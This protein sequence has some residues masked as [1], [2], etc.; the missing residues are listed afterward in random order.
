MLEG[1]G[2]FSNEPERGNSM[3]KKGAKHFFIWAFYLVVFML[4]A[5]IIFGRKDESA[6]KNDPNKETQAEFIK[7]EILRKWVPGK[8]G[9]AMEILVSPANTK[10]EVIALAKHLKEENLKYGQVILFIYDLREAC[11]NRDNDKYPEEKYFKHFLLSMWVP[12][13]NR[14]DPEIKWEAKGRE[15]PKKKAGG[16]ALTPKKSADKPKSS[17]QI[18]QEEKMMKDML[19][20]GLVEKINPELNEA[21][22]DPSVWARMKYQDKEYL[23]RFLAFYCGKKKGTNLNWVDIRD[24]YT[25]KKFAKY[26]EAWGFKVY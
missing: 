15:E 10:E 6:N 26:S 23:G 9:I 24:S 16:P 1:H 22:V 20:A 2:L 5:P 8:S 18:F 19:E 17:P 4:M 21:F 25:G 14:D 7:Y 11:L 13:L 3:I 12:P